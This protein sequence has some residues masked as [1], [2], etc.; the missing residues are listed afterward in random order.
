MRVRGKPG[1]SATTANAQAIYPAQAEVGLGARGIY[2]GP[3]R[4]GGAFVYD[5]WE[6]YNAGVLTNP[7]CLIAGSIGS[8]KS[9][10]AKSLV[11]RS[12]VFRNRRVVII[13]PKSEYGP[14]TRALG[15]EP[16]ALKPGGA[17]RLNPLHPGDGSAEAQ[18]TQAVMLAAVTSAALGRRL[19]EIEQQ[20]NVEALREVRRNHDEPTI[21]YV[22]K[23]LLSPS[24]EMAQALHMTKTQ[25]ADGARAAALALRGLCEGPLAGMFDGPST[26][27][28]DF[29][30]GIVTL[31]LSAVGSDDAIGIMMACAFG[32]LSQEIARQRRL[33]MAMRNLWIY[34]EAWRIFALP[35]IAEM[36]QD[37]M[38]ISRSYGI[39]NVLIT[40]RLTDL[41]AAG[42]TGSR[43][44]NLVKG[45]LE[46]VGTHVIYRQE[47]GAESLLR[48]HY[49]VTATEMEMIRSAG[50][51]IALW[52]V[53]E[54]R[55]IVRHQL[56]PIFEPQIIDTDQQMTLDDERTRAEGSEVA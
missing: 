18:R 13:D 11:L 15:A 23:R 16:I 22:T 2:I 10:L 53:G 21:A 42:D 3:S 7:N 47:P 17:I 25:L 4:L 44:Q 24:A 6:L 26:G 29:E 56:S 1:H 8:G 41:E 9:A 45:M 32:W 30:R 14:L 34:D 38:K 37:R 51:G 36:L 50:R 20:A 52:K 43:T 46:D 19:S 35:G 5:P 54:R 48:E 39:S 12:Q 33:N 28:V 40:H 49:R 27:E 31:D 55:F